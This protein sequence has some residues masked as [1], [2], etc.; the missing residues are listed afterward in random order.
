MVAPIVTFNQANISGPASREVPGARPARDATKGSGDFTK[1]LGEAIDKV[2]ANLKNADTSAEQFVKGK[3]G[4]HEMAMS[5]EKADLSLRLLMRVRNRVIEA[6][7][8]ISR[9]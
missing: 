2:D 1:S 8:E 5:L 7:R 4:I 6:Y 3:T 9:M